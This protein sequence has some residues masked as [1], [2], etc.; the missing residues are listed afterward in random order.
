M[1][2]SLPSEIML[3][4]MNDEL[5]NSLRALMRRDV[6]N[7]L[8]AGVSLLVLQNGEEVFFDAQGYADLETKQPIRRD[9]IFRMYSMT[10][11]VTAAAAMLLVQ[12]GELDL[13][14]PVI[15]VLPGFS[16]ANVRGN[17]LQRPVTVLHLL[18]M[19]SG[20]TYGDEATPEGRQ[21]LDYVAACEKRLHSDSAVT[22]VEFANALGHIPLA[23]QP[24]SSW[25]YGFSADVLGAVI[26]QVAGMRFGA[27]LEE[28]LFKPLNMNDTGFYVPDEKNSRL[29][30]AYEQLPDGTLTRY[31]GDH[32]LIR[33]AMDLPPRFESGGAGLVSTIDDY[34]R[35][36]QMLL[37]GGI[38][39]G[40]RI[41]SPKVV[42]YLTSG[43]LTPEQQSAMR[44]FGGHEGYTYSHLLRRLTDPGQA[45][46]MSSAGEYGWAGWL[47]CY[48]ANIPAEN[49][50]IVL[51]QQ[52][53]GAGTSSLT[54]RLRNM[55]SAQL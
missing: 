52:K 47:G 19:T 27:F 18:N 33:N 31:A 3:N 6:E 25:H 20:L 34:A 22:T 38:L 51:M 55:I 54:R 46:L 15:E 10:K 39:D 48:F 40:V 1:T 49:T 21:L 42:E 36:S 11:P 7:S 30:T 53:K 8:T 2:G 13:N 9:H 43:A 29:V 28:N 26:E 45:C 24:D 44:H 5:K 35:F 23:F 32:L 4:Y 14:M 50:T 17:P 41:L 16:H 37:N 12:R